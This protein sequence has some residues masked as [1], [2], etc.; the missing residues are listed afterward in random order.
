M[1]KCIQLVNSIHL[2]NSYFNIELYTDQFL[3]TN[4]QAVKS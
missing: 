2:K 3:K 1:S 4:D